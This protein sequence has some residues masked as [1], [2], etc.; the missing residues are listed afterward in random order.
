MKRLVDFPSNILDTVEYS[1][2][3]K[4]YE[5]AIWIEIFHKLWSRL[6]LIGEGE[7]ELFSRKSSL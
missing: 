1:L 6:E 3:H 2:R 7:R 4:C 5:E